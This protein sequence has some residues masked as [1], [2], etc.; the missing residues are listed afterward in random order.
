MRKITIEISRA[1]R[2]R[3]VKTIGNS[4]TDGNAL[5]LFNNRIAE[6]RD[7]SLW[8]TNAG[9]DS[10]T[11]KERLNGLDG[12]RIH[13]SRGQWYLNG[14][15]W[16][17]SWVEVGTWGEWASGT[18][19]NNEV[20]FDTSS[21]WMGEYSKPRYSVFH[22]FLEADLEK[23]ESR[24]SAEGIPTKRMDS[25]TTGVYRPNYFVVVRPED[26][27]RAVLCL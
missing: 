14:I 24:L 2:N 27:E 10:T 3:E 22:T 4:R 15:E 23:V 11:T 17:G 9:W 6:Y 25:D 18:I 8:I 5:F 26:V 20:E 13:Q 12:V 21:V 16:D 7:G 1:F 19:D